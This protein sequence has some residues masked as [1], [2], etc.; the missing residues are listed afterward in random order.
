M[1]AETDLA[2]QT[3]EPCQGKGTPMSKA[4]AQELLASVHE[5]WTLNE[6]AT[7]ITRAF[8]VKGFAK[9]VYLANAA[10]FHADR[11]GHHPD[12]E[13]GWGYCKI[14]YTSHELGG[15]SRNDFICAAK[16][17]KQVA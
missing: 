16:F 2:T 3:C 6:A 12:V 17:D 11:E 1:S 7:A 5:D 13:F 10:A 15:L 8:K 4:E 9:A 14:T